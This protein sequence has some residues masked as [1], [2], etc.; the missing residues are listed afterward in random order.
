MISHKLQS[1]RISSSSESVYLFVR[2]RFSRKVALMRVGSWSIMVTD[3]LNPFRGSS[4]ID[5]PSIKILPADISVTPK[6]VLIIV[7]FPAPV[8]P[9]IP[10]FSPLLILQVIPLMTSGRSFLYLTFTLS[11]SNSPFFMVPSCCS[12]YMGSQLLQYSAYRLSGSISM[13]LYILSIE[14]N[15][16]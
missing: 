5:C 6:R 9:T 1:L 13:N 14:T 16:V 4:S 10:I 7:V 3:C 12:S 15:F 8:L 2:S 11:N